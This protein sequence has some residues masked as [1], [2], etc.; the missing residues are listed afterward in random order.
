MTAGAQVVRRTLAAGT[1]TIGAVE[2]ADDLSEVRCTYEGDGRRFVEAITF[3]GPASEHLDATQVAPLLD[4]LRVVLATSYFKVQPTERVHVE[5]TL[6][7][8]LQAIADALFGPGLAEYYH[9]NGFDPAGAPAIDA[10]DRSAAAQV[11]PGPGAE[12]TLVP[13]GGGKDSAL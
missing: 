10:D 12:G 11:V 13:L 6:D 7:D 4:L 8:E 5:G 9:R 3:E 1:F 2:A